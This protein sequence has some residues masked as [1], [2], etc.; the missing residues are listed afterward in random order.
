MKDSIKIAI[1]ASGYLAI[2]GLQYLYDKPIYD[3]SLENIPNLQE[4]LSTGE[5]DALA[6]YTNIGG[7]KF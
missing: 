3:W 4:K 1:F 2:I 5:W 6:F 7:G